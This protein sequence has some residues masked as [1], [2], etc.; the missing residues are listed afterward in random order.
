MTKYEFL[1]ELREALEGQ[2]PMSE[3]KDSISYYRDYFS[4]QEADGRSEQEILEELGSPRLIAKSIIETKGGEQI[5]YEDT[6]EEQVNE[7]EGS[8]KVFV[9]DSFLTK[10]GCLAAVIIV[11]ILI[12]SVFAVALR[13]IGPIIMILLL[14]YLIKNVFGKR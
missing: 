12:G 4:R 8:P 6:Y 3:I 1:K 11:I 14:I 2:V 10:I 13:F 7:E 5:Y 9:F